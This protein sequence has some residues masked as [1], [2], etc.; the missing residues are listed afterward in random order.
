MADRSDPARWP[1]LHDLFAV[2]IGARTQDDWV[3]TFAG[4]DA[5]VAPVRSL[6]EAQQDPHLVARGTFVEHHGVT[7]PAPAP[8]FSRTTTAL[9]RPP[10]AAGEHTDEVLA[11]WLG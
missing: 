7:Q 2:V 9:H 3:E 6:L 5:C 10:P 4:S 11:D 1:D 8:R